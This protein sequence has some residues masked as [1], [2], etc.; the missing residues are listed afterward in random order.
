MTITAQ[1]NQK[2]MQ[3]QPIHDLLLHPVCFTDSY[4]LLIHDQRDHPAREI[5]YLHRHDCLELGL[6]VKGD[7]I[8]VVEGKILNFSAGDFSFIGPSEAHLAASSPGTTSHWIWFYFDSERILLPRFPE[9]DLNFLHLLRGGNFNNIFDGKRHPWGAYFLEELFKA[10]S[11][12]EK[13]AW[14]LLMLTRL[15]KFIPATAAEQTECGGDFERIARAITYFG[16]KYA[17]P[18]SIAEAAR[19]CGMSL[20]NFRRVFKNE[21]G[22]SPL[23]YLNRLRISLA[24]AELCIGKR[25]ISEIAP[26]C[27]FP[28]LS[29]FNRQFKKQT[30]H[31]PRTFQAQTSRS[32]R[33]S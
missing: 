27:G 7:G 10:Q 1:K 21:T 24:K 20:T 26:Y 29:S 13:T 4:P 23:D 9:S 33:I 15:R 5:V 12:E 14:L 3:N 22:E 18:I 30:G 8:F 19:L 32:G 6:C 17:E 28:S 31:S 2:T 25:R 16:R 11:E